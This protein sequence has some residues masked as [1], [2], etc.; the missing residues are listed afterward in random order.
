MNI[1]TGFVSNS[2]STSYIICIDPKEGPSNWMSTIQEVY[3]EESKWF[4]EDPSY[5]IDDVINDTKLLQNGGEIAERNS[6][7][8][9][10]IKDIV[11]DLRMVIRGQEVGDFDGTI[12]NICTPECYDKIQILL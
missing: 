6:A 4:N 9:E 11:S 3:A 10:I 1:R 7:R 8:F 2:S 5:T 12:T